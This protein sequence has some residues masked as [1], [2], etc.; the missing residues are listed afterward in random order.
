MDIL[1]IVKQIEENLKKIIPLM[2]MR[3]KKLAECEKIAEEAMMAAEA[4]DKEYKEIK[5]QYE[6]LTK[7][8]EALTAGGFPQETEKKTEVKTEEKKIEDKNVIKTNKKKIEQII[9]TR[10][11]GTLY[12]YDRD[13]SFL[14]KYPSQKSAARDLGWDQ[15]SISRFMKFPIE[16]QIQKKGFYLKWVP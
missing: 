16:K 15:S 6:A 2:E 1:E 9:F 5:G 10:K 12:R 8:K 13:H 14:G 3:E 11:S 7:A 4:A